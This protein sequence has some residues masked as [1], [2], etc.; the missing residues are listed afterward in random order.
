MV[1]DPH[2][3]LQ[4]MPRPW[5]YISKRGLLWRNATESDPLNTALEYFNF[6][7]QRKGSFLYRNCGGKPSNGY[8]CKKKYYARF[9][10]PRRR[11]IPQQVPNWC[12][13]GRKSLPSAF[14]WDDVSRKRVPEGDVILL[15]GWGIVGTCYNGHFACQTTSSA[16]EVIFPTHQL[17]RGVR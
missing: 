10:S 11:G 14:H 17:D 6:S 4:Q 15:G 7:R 13:T 2:S 1:E 12:T 8:E 3:K 16:V 5:R 9:K